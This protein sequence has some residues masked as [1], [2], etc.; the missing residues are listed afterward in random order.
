MLYQLC[1]GCSADEKR[2]LQLL[3][4]HEFRYLGNSARVQAR[5]DSQVNEMMA[6]MLETQAR[7]RARQMAATS[8]DDVEPPAQR[9]RV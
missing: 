5:V 6:A 7:V 4:A 2:E 1:A 3:Q 9:Q 8:D